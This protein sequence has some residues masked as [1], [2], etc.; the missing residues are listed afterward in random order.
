MPKRPLKMSI[1]IPEYQ[2]PRNT[3]REAVHRLWRNANG[4]RRSD[5][6][7]ATG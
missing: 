5:T 1:R 4:L 2:S 7:L 6:F 3:W